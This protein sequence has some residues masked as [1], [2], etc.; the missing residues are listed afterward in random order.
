[1]FWELPHMSS[2]LSLDVIKMAS[3]FKSEVLS[4]RF[5]NWFVWELVLLLAT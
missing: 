2:C 5:W 4:F 3:D 1:M